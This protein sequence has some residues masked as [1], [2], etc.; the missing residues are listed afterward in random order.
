MIFIWILPISLCM[1]FMNRGLLQPVKALPA[2]D[3]AQST[4]VFVPDPSVPPVITQGA[5]TR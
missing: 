2:T 1:S 4:V 5:G 3:N